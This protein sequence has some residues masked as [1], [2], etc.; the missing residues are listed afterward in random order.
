LVDCQPALALNRVFDHQGVVIF[1][2][3]CKLGRLRM[4]AAH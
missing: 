3:A 2:H 1:E 4:L